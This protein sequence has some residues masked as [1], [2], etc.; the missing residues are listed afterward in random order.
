[1]NRLRV[2]TRTGQEGN[3]GL[4]EI[5]LARHRDVRTFEWINPFGDH[6]LLFGPGFV[7]GGEWCTEEGVLKGVHNEGGVR[8][9]EIE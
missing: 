6:D 7:V 3:T 5:Y 9:L 1:M 8:L 2:I 4:C